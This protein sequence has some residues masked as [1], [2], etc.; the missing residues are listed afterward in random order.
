MESEISGLTEAKQ[1]PVRVSL[2]E[3]ARRFASPLTEEHA[4][5]VIYQLTQRFLRQRESFE[6]G[7]INPSYRSNQN[8]NSRVVINL[9]SVL[10]SED[11]EVDVKTRKR[12][13]WE[14][15]IFIY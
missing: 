1:L 12:P 14:G 4:W 15:E 10:L 7:G 6:R 2:K 9:E 5:A 13:T 3:I 8:R 11:G